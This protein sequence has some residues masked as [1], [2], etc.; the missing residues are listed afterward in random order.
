MMVNKEW[1]NRALRI[2]K[3]MPCGGIEK[4]SDSELAELEEDQSPN[5]LVYAWTQIA[6][7]YLLK[8]RKIK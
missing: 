2:L 8:A 4:I 1:F 7:N 3:E 6:Y 5:D